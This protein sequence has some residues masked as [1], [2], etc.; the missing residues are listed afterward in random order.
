MLDVNERTTAKNGDGENA[1][2]A[3]RMTGHERDEVI[4]EESC[5]LQRGWK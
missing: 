2:A 1:G 3:F 4:R 5:I